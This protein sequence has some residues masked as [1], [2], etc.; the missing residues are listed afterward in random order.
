MVKTICVCGVC[1]E[2]IQGNSKWKTEYEMWEHIKLAHP[3]EVLKMHDTNKAIYEKIHALQES[4]VSL[5][6]TEVR[7][8]KH[9]GSWT[10]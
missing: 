5:Y 9:R 1:D 8:K 10:I 6:T 3:N 7:G 2:I 4:K